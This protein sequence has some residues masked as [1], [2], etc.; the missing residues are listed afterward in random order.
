MTEKVQKYIIFFF[1]G[2]LGYFVYMP[3]EAFPV[4]Q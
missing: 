4:T 1:G 3:Q 2:G